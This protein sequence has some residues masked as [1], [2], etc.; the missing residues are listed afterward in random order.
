MRSPRAK[1]S[2]GYLDLFSPSL[3]ATS[4]TSIAA[5]FIGS[6]DTLI[7]GAALPTISQ[8]LHGTELYAVALG[9]YLVTSLIGMPLFG[10]MSDRRGPWPSFLLAAAIFSAGAL[11]GGA[12]P[13]MPVLVLARAVQGFGA[14]GLFSVGYGAIGRQLPPA[15]QPYGFGLM[16]ATW[17]ASSILGPAVGA[18][19]IATAG[20]RWVF[21][22][23]LPLMLV[24]LPAARAAYK[25]IG[26]ATTSA[27]STNVRGPVLLGVTAAA[28]LAALS[29]TG[30]WI[31][32][33]AALTVAGALAFARDER[34]ATQP[35][36]EAL[37]RPS[38]PGAGAIIS[39]CLT[40]IAIVSLQAYLPL[41]LQTGRGAPVLIA[42]GILAAGSLAWTFGSMVS[43]KLITHGTRWLL[44]GGHGSFVIGAMLLIAA[45]SISLG[46]NWIYIGYMIAGL[47]IGLLTPSL[48]TL[49]LTDARRGTEGASTASVQA[50]RALG[51]GLGAGMAGLAFRLSVPQQL[52]DLLSA[53]DPVAAIQN[54]GLVPYMDGALIAC[55]LVALGAIFVSA[56]VVLRLPGVRPSETPVAE[57]V[58]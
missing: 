6:L 45:V 49:G 20:W 11:L 21:W 1:S 30:I 23:N 50:L 22:F 24:I 33:L 38:G 39:A 36:L 4:L 29:A 7:I 14:G 26:S 56:A 18:I 10:A 5:V 40:G 35:V 27:A 19:F 17:G 34:R 53:P 58:V 32:P 48:F 37:R 41:Y 46:N 44:S 57:M 54:A 8:R 13:T 28:A 42:G 9:A 12:A 47:G 25:G 55:W 15:L 3:R 2:V 16:S 43:A 52:F 31:L 51:S